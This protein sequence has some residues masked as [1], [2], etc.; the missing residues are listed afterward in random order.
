MDSVPKITT[1][2]IATDTLCDSAF[3]TGA[4][5]ITAAAPQILQPDAVR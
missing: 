5:A 3:V 4:A 2:A 1:T